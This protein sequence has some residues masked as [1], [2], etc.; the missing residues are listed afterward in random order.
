[1][2]SV[3]LWKKQIMIFEYWQYWYENIEVWKSRLTY[4]SRFVLRNFLLNWFC[5]PIQMN[6]YCNSGVAR[7]FPGGWLSPTRRAKLRKKMSNVWGN[8]IKIDHDLRKNEESGTLAHSG[9]WGWL[10]PW[11]CQLSFSFFRDFWSMNCYLEKKC[12]YHWLQPFL[13]DKL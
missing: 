9:L 6:S 1:M 10:W 7:A 13:F 11:C 5:L 4:K 2:C 3:T 8:I 12:M